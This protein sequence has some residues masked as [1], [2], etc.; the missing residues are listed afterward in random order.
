MAQPSSRRKGLAY[1]RRKCADHFGQQTITVEELVVR[2]KCLSAARKHRRHHYPKLCALCAK[3]RDVRPQLKLRG[4][5]V[6][7]ITGARDNTT[8]RFVFTERDT[9]SLHFRQQKLRSRR[10]SRSV[11]VLNRRNYWLALYWHCCRFGAKE[12]EIR[13]VVRTKLIASHLGFLLVFLFK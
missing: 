7:C 6:R 8:Y 2:Y 9:Q 10:S 11:L 13:F 5:F 12:K 1:L 3:G 4:N